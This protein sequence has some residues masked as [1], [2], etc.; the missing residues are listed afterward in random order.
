MSMKKIVAPLLILASFALAGCQ[1]PFSGL[2]EKDLEAKAVLL[3]RE[4]IA[5]DYQ[6][7][8]IDELHALQ[9][10]DPKAL[11]IDTMPLEDSYNK[12]HVPGA[13]QFLFP[14]P[15]MPEWNTG[16]TA[17]KTQDE[18]IAMLGPDKDR[19]LIFYCGFVKC[20]RSHNGAIWARKLG[21]NNVYRMPG[22]IIGWKEAGYPADS[23]K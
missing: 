10:K 22:G 21:Y 13:V 1:N 2:S 15:P 5:G 19:P 9:A 3:A 18:F 6:L 12:N 20:T 16:E 7:M 4:T 23:V 11:V 8:T 17:G 14:I